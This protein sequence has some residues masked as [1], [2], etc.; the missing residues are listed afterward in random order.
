M[1]HYNNDD[2]HH[3]MIHAHISTRLPKQPHNVHKHMH[4]TTRGDL[5]NIL[6]LL[7]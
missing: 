3:T 7:L 4:K 6:V 5:M 1:K 2:C